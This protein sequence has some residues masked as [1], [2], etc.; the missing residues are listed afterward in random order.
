[1]TDTRRWMRDNSPRI[2]ALAVLYLAMAALLALWAWAVH[3][4]TWAIILTYTVATALFGHH[5][6][7]RHRARQ[8]A[9]D[10]PRSNPAR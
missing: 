2:A 8:A 3:P 9:Q 10:A 1:M 6:Y 5:A 7:R 4:P